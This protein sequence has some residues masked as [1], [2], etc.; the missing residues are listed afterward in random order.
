[1]TQ[2]QKNQ[3]KKARRGKMLDLM[4]WGRFPNSRSL[5]YRPDFPGDL[6][7][8]FF[9]GLTQNPSEKSYILPRGAGRSYGDQALNHAHSVILS[10]KWDRLLEFAPATGILVAESGVTFADIIEIFLPQGWIMPV[11]PGTGF[12]TLGGAV[13]NDVHG[14]NH[15][16][17]GSFA[18]F[19]V[20]FDL[21]L[22]SGVVKRVDMTS[23][24]RL[25]RATVGGSGLTGMILR[26]AVRLQPIA[27][28]HVTVSYRRMTNLSQ[29]IEALRGERARAEAA[30]PQNNKVLYS[31]GWI[32]ALA[33][34]KNLGR[35]ILESSEI[36]T[37]D[38]SQGSDV[39]PA[40]GGANKKRQFPIDLPSFALNR[41]VIRGFN[42]IYYRRIPK[43][44]TERR[45]PLA[46]FLFPLDAIL[47][48]NRLYGRAGFQQFQCVLPDETAE[49]AL[50]EIL[51][52][53]QKIGSAS[54]LA[55]I[56]SLGGEGLGYL[57]FPKRGMTLALD[58]PRRAGSDELF[59]TLI[60]ITRRY[61][62]RVYLAKDSALTAEDMRAMY[63]N[64]PEFLSVRQE[65]DPTSL[66]SSNMARRLGL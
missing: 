54:F 38:G 24:P 17:M 16:Q 33:S 66:F 41:A 7:A 42:E 51:Q 18:H 53:S 43:S 31:V 23:E 62:G 3:T 20:W 1:M 37:T 63:P 13:A 28:P 57:S 40:T 39:V 49:P 9:T 35:G 21:M 6:S 58:F 11:Q 4:G 25:F 44:G 27:S 10:K 19:L 22:P 8:D 52:T 56:K 2:Q 64:L 29:F 26:V 45:I 48:W 12:V 46:Q 14:K 32:D 50:S 30:T 34:G 47:D 65:S 60:A 5:V 15:D 61:D 55:V 59:R 36:L